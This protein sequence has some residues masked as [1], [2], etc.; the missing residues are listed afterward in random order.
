MKIKINRKRLN[1]MAKAS[2]FPRF[3]RLPI[4]TFVAG[5]LITTVALGVD[6]ENGKVFT[7]SVKDRYIRTTC[8]YDDFTCALAI[9][10]DGAY[11]MTQ[12]RSKEVA[13]QV[14]VR[15][16]KQVAENPETCRVLDYRGESEF[17]E[18]FSDLAKKK[19][20]SSII[21][22]EGVAAEVDK[23]QVNGIREKLLQLRSLVDEGL[24]S[25]DDYE[26]AKQP[27]IQ[28]FIDGC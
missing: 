5:C 1:S 15:L 27:I 2:F 25:E 9:S 22:T 4:S 20:A 28:K 7:K 23:I 19:H 17:I 6:E 3:R 14:A 10:D 26:K 21:E 24:I 12:E 11:G 8:Y 16:C 13:R 18:N